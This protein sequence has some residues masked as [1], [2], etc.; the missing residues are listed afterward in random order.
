MKFSTALR[1]AGRHAVDAGGV[2]ISPGRFVNSGGPPLALS[3]GDAR[4]A[5]L[6]TKLKGNLCAA[7]QRGSQWEIGSALAAAPAG[8]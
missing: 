4:R 2:S 5:M 6:A 1:L 3:Q 8:S 7:L